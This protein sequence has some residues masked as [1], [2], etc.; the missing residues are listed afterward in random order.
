MLAVHEDVSW[1]TCE[2]GRESYLTNG[3]GRIAFGQSRLRPQPAGPPI[4]HFRSAEVALTQLAAREPFHF[5]GIHCQI[6]S[7]GVAPSIGVVLSAGLGSRFGCVLSRAVR[8]EVARVA[9]AG[10]L[11]RHLNDLLNRAAAA[12]VRRGIPGGMRLLRYRRAGGTR[13]SPLPGFLHRRARRG[14]QFDAPH[15]GCRSLPERFPFSE[16]VTPQTT[17]RPGDLDAAL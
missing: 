3:G 14:E 16:L 6:L 8:R 17:V 4:R 7:V 12:S 11:D 5:G 2:S 1:G 15:Q 9:D 13:S 10:R